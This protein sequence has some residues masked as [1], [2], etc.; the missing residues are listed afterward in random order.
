[1]LALERDLKRAVHDYLAILEA[2]GKLLWLRLNA[3]MLIME[4]KGKKRAVNLCRPG[5]ADYLV[6]QMRQGKILGR[7]GEEDV[8]WSRSVFLEIKAPGG[9][10]T[11]A[12]KDFQKA[13]EAQGAEYLIIRDLEVLERELRG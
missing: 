6:L 4:S 7:N 1:M 8:I 5:T 12:Q 11:Q 9:E 13:V 3:G 2:Q 10:Q